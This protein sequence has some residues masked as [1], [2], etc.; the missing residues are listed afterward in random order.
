MKAKTKEDGQ[1]TANL[2]LSSKKHKITPTL[3][4]ILLL[5]ICPAVMAQQIDKYIYKVG[6]GDIITLTIIAGGVEQAKSDLVVSEQGEVTLPF[7]GNIKASGLTLKNLEKKLYIPLEKDYFVDPQVNIQMKEYNS[8]S[9][10]ISGAVSTPGKFKLDFHPSIM[11]LIAQAGGVV[12]DRGNV[13]YVIRES[14]GAESDP[15]NINLSKLLDEGDM[16]RNI[17]LQT[18]DKIYIPLAKRLNQAQTKIYLEGEIKKPGMIDFQPGLTVL[19]AC[20]MAGGFDKYAAPGR[21]RI[22]RMEG[23]KL[24]IIKV[25]LDKIKDGELADVTLK[26]GD[27]IHIPESWL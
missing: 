19:S 6:P 12:S 9:F 17:M 24:K 26:P 10:T 13:A 3:I 23:E 25:D 7:I 8:L 21:A 11:D 15:I 4:L 22:I 1:L 27:R 2:L 16:S 5:S 14:Q 20:I 18:G